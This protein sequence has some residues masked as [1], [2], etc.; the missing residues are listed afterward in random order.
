MFH[1]YTDDLIFCIKNA[2]YSVQDYQENKKD[3]PK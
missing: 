2:L 3:D 1:R